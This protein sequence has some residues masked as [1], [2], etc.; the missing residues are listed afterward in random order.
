MRPVIASMADEDARH[1]NFP[2]LA[3]HT[4]PVHTIRYDGQDL[5]SASTFISS[6]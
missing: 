6:S 1:H 2:G 4:L 3:N 5:H